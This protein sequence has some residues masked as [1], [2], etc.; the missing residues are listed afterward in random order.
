[1]NKYKL[2]S[3]ERGVCGEKSFVDILHRRGYLIEEI[4]DE[5][6]WTH[7]ID[8]IFW[9]GNK[10]YS[11]DVKAL[12]KV[13]RWDDRV[14]PEII[15]VEFV[16]VRGNDGWLYGKADYLAFEGMKSFVVVKTK[17]LAELSEK[18]V[19]KKN[20]VTSSKDALYS[21]Y[22]RKGK[23]DE[24]SILP[25]ADLFKIPHQIV[26]KVPYLSWL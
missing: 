14:N 7:H 9:K 12:K 6:Q 23:K 11:I 1:M 18:L 15:W 20:R 22:N 24:I 4:K 25:Y 26:E 19:D 17:D 5:R 8:F 10:E 2:E 13:S 3:L 16:N 21:L